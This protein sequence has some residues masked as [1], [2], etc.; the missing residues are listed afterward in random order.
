MTSKFTTLTDCIYFNCLFFLFFP[1]GFIGF[2]LAWAILFCC[3]LAVTVQA[4][5]NV[6]KVNVI[7]H[8]YSP[9]IFPVFAYD[10][11]PG[12]RNPLKPDD[13]RVYFCLLTLLVACFWGVLAVFFLE[14]TWI[15]LGVH[16][17]S[18]VL[19]T[20]YALECSTQP[21]V[22]M[23]NAV[24]YLGEGSET[25]KE[26]VHRAKLAVNTYSNSGEIKHHGTIMRQIIFL[27]LIFFLYVPYLFDFSIF[28][29]RSVPN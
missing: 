21:R 6:S 17:L 25:Y 2:S 28:S 12:V 27:I 18:I 4:H 9:N 29:R 26:A 16:A 7:S 1:D 8:L 23:A 20:I 11:S 15:G 22:M 24:R 3:L 5:R 19:L 10:L 14:K 13:R